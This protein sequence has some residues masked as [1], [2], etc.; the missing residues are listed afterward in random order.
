MF[1][2]NFLL[3]LIPEARIAHTM[4][5]YERAVFDV[6][7]IQRW[8]FNRKAGPKANKNYPLWAKLAHACEKHAVEPGDFF[9]HTV[10]LWKRLQSRGKTAGKQA[11][12]YVSQLL[13]PI[14]MKRYLET[15]PWRIRLRATEYYRWEILEGADMLHEFCGGTFDADVIRHVW[16]ALPPSFLAFN[17]EF[18]LARRA[19]WV[20]EASAPRLIEQVDSLRANLSAAPAVWRELRDAYVASCAAKWRPAGG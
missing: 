8:L 7:G 20:R 13:S 9:F 4:R 5:A 10:E 6:L 3:E 15:S 18:E 1:D 2:V 19:V 17:V 14:Y 16:T 11:S 12:P